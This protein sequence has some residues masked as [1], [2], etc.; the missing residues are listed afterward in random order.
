MP[1]AAAAACTT[2]A[3]RRASSTLS[4]RVRMSV[5]TRSVCTVIPARQED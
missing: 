1:L 2:R 3:L 4:T 5:A